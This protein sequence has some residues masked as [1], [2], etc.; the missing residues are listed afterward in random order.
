[1]D[2]I[3]YASK[4]ISWEEIIQKALSMNDVHLLKLVFVCHEESVAEN[5]KEKGDKG[6]VYKETAFKNY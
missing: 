3:E 6:C 4:L 2:F 5:L 1:M